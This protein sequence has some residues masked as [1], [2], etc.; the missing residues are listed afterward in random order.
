M[1]SDI[2]PQKEHLSF[3]VEQRGGVQ[4]ARLVKDALRLPQ[5]SRQAVDDFGRKP[6]GVNR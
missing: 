4:P 2:F 6:G 3:V 1:P 5:R